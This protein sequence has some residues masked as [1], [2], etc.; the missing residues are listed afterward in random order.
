MQTPLGLFCFQ[1]TAGLSPSPTDTSKAKVGHHSFKMSA[2]MH[3]E[4]HA[5]SLSLAVL[6]HPS[7]FGILREKMRDVNSFHPGVSTVS[8]S[9]NLAVT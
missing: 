8:S 5:I 6:V 2:Q 9:C 1:E 4:K 7:A 3:P